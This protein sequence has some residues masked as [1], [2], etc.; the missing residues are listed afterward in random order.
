M[1]CAAFSVYSL[2]RCIIFAKDFIEHERKEDSE[3]NADLQ[4]NGIT[5]FMML[6]AANRANSAKVYR[7]WHWHVRFGSKADMAEC[8]SN[9]RFTPKSGHGSAQSRCPLCAMCGRI[10]TPP[11]C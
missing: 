8:L 1:Q 10:W 11:D 9:V 3:H 7:I 6:S 2:G 4:I 5:N